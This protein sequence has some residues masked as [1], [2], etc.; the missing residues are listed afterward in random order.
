[1]DS[2]RAASTDAP[3]PGSLGLGGGRVPVG[4]VG[5]VTH[6]VPT[7]GRTT[8]GSVVGWGPVARHDPERLVTG[9]TPQDLE[10]GCQL[11]ERGPAGEGCPIA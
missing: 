7:R 11:Q 4:N 1:M 10:V 9:E 8:Y 3:E 5:G 6:Q 2:V